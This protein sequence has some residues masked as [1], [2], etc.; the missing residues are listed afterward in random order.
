MF[1]ACCW[2][3]SRPVPCVVHV[4]EPC[5]HVSCLRAARRGAAIP[6][7]RAFFT[8]MPP[9]QKRLISFFQSAVVLLWYIHTAYIENARKIPFGVCRSLLLDPYSTPHPLQ[10]LTYACIYLSYSL[11]PRLMLAGCRFRVWP[12]RA[13]SSSTESL[14]RLSRSSMHRKTCASRW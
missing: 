13:S 3:S 11:L 8:R 4:L 5:T 14:T 12:F 6:L 10:L 2:R 9:R 7:S 1:F